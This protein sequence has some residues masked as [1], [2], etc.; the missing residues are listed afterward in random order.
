M[1]VGDIVEGAGYREYRTRSGIIVREGADG[2]A[3]PRWHAV[4]GY[5]TVLNPDG[6]IDQQTDM[7]LNA[8]ADEGEQ[9]MIN[10]S[11]RNT[12][13]L[14]TMYLGLCNDGTIAETD[15]VATIAGEVPTANGYARQ[16]I[17]A[18]DWA[19]PVLNSG[20]YQSTATEESFGPASTGAWTVTH[21]FLTTTAS[22]TGGL[23]I[24]YVP[25]S[26]TTTVAI[27]QS[28]RY[29]LTFKQQ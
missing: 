26:A 18:A 12:G 16:A 3:R 25:L 4:G 17:A 21:A 5:A 28:F 10:A 11:F 15:T 22:G 14:A 2:V 23:H 7:V 27:G 24:L 13:A 20:D 29:T 6:S 1:P 19:A 9:Y 8:L